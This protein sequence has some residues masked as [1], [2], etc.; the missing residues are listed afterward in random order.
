MRARLR[1][2]A[3]TLIAVTLLTASTCG[4]DRAALTDSPSAGPAAG[5]ARAGTVPDILRFTGTALDGSPYDGA[6]LAGRPTVLWFWE[7]S[8]TKCRAQGSEVMM[9]ADMFEGDLGVIGVAGA[10]DPA[11]LDEFVT[12]TGA[13]HLRHLTDPGRSIWKRFG[14]DKPGSY[15]LFDAAGEVA[16]RGADLDGRLTKEVTSLMGGPGMR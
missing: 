16:V 7:P 8:C 12:A 14:I 3:L 2:L 1:P 10:G 4:P 9:T 5:G 15:V 6:Q 13:R 11:S